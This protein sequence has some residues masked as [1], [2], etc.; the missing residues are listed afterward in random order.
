MRPIGP[1]RK[2]RADIT[3]G[4]QKCSRA[5]LVGPGRRC[6]EC[7]GQYDPAYV[8]LE[9][10]GLLDDPTYMAGMPED[11]PLKRRENVFAFSMACA[12]AEVLELLRA[13]LAPSG[14]PD[15]G[16]GLHHW[17]TGTV[18]REAPDCQPGCPFST[19]LLAAGDASGLTV[20]GRHAAAEE[21]RARR[22]KARQTDGPPPR[23]WSL[24][25]ALKSLFRGADEADSGRK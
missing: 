11:H 6:L 15:V 18:T 21:S 20:T 23:R 19:S 12:A 1:G 3:G 7:L 24:R 14:I 17:T 16:A 9:R 13:V 10:D 25:S 5:H 4:H 2:L 22:N 8:Q